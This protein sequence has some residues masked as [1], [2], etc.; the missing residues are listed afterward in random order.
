MN[1]VIESGPW[2]GFEVIHRCTHSQAIEDGAL[3]DVTALAGTCGFRLPV[4]M[5]TAVFGDCWRWGEAAARDD[6]EASGEFFVERVLRFACETLRR[7]A[8][9]APGDRL[10][11]PLDRFA[12]RPA[13]AFVHVGPGDDGESVVTLMYPGE[14]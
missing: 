11:L 3:V 4:A 14:A 13:P 5:T 8:G 6:E 10:P 2:A 7:A 1:E 9:R 12:G